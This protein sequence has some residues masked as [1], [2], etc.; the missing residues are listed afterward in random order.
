M[1]NPVIIPKLVVQ[2]PRNSASQPKRQCQARKGHRRRDAPVADE[3]AHVGLEADH[4]EVQHQTEVCNEIEVDDGL[5]REDGVA[6]SWDM[7]H[8]GGAEDDAA[9]NLGD[10]AGLADLGE[11]PVEDMA[12]DDDQ[13]GLD[14]VSLRTGGEGQRRGRTWMMNRTMGS[15]ELYSDGLA[16]SMTPPCDGARSPVG[17]ASAEAEV[18]VERIELVVVDMVP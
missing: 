18:S 5:R 4:E 6:K 15:L 8:D 3:E 7:A 12:E 13:T 17:V 10:D 11:R 2:P 9:D 1:L 14:C 16:P